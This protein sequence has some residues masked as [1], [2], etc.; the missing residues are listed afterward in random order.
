MQQR[1]A[2]PRRP[3]TGTVQARQLM[4]P[5]DRVKPVGHRIEEVQHGGAPEANHG[6]QHQR[7]PSIP[8]RNARDNWRLGAHL[9]EI[10]DEVGLIRS[11]IE[12]GQ[13]EAPEKVC[14]R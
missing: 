10:L 12:G 1:M 2:G 3:A 8:V 9:I 4:K 6:Q 5:A 13:A 14:G 7:K 11:Q